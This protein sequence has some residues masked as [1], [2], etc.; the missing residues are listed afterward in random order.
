[1]KTKFCHV[2][3]EIPVCSLIQY[4]TLINL[5]K[6]LG[7]SAK[8]LSFPEENLINPIIVGL[9]SP[10]YIIKGPPFVPWNKIQ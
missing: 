1:M 7:T 5:M 4:T 6:S 8:Y 2:P 3:I 10:S 9:P